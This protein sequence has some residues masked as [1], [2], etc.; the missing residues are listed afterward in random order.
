MKKFSFALLFFTASCTAP[1]RINVSNS[2]NNSSVV[3]QGKIYTTAYQQR[4][5]EYRALCFQ[6]YNIAHQRVD[7]IIL[8]QTGKP[9]VIVTDIDETILDNSAFEAHQTL[10][11]KGYE[12]DAWYEWSAMI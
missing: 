12:S 8:T 2:G 1:Q 5:A 10:Q 6:A 11:G 3:T 9:K 4:A 7:E